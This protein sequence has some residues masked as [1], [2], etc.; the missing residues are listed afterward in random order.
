MVASLLGFVVMLVSLAVRMGALL[1]KLSRSTS[2]TRHCGHRC[3]LP[4]PQI[5]AM[6]DLIII[7]LRNSVCYSSND[8]QANL[9][10]LFFVIC[11]ED[12]Y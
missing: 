2:A 8:W 11:G 7:R 3:R 6:T 5:R 10:L 1:E 9:Y 12:Q 4:S